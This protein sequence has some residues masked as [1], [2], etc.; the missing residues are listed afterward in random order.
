[1]A[2]VAKAAGV[3]IHTLSAVISDKPDVLS[4]DT[5]GATAEFMTGKAAFWLH[6]DGVIATVRQAAP[7][8]MN[9]PGMD[10]DVTLFPWVGKKSIKRQFPGGGRVGGPL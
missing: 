9:P 1:M 6:Y 7:P 10:L 5:D 4:L 2:A 3:S 8:Q